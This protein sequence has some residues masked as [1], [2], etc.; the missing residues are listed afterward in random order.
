MKKILLATALSAALSTSVQADTLL[1]LYVGG[2]IWATEASGTFGDNANNQADFNLDDQ[3]QGSFYVAFEHPLPLIPNVKVARTSLDTDGITTLSGSVDFRGET[4]DTTS[5]VATKFD[6]TYTDYTLYYEIFDNDL[7]S[8]D[9]GITG[10]DFDTEITLTQEGK[11]SGTLSATGIVPM[12]YAYTNIGLPFTGFNVFG[13][14]NFLSVGDHSLY[15]FQVGVSYE[16]IDNLAV[17][18]NLTL[19]YR[20][21]QLEVD[22]L[23]NLYSNLD[24]KGVFAGA[25]VHF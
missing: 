5:E 16:L 8:V 24:F 3:S 9:F 4:Y 12:L 7:V 1:G 23:D 2:Q 10:R 22:D 13:E 15:D 14:G 21:V 19:G 20:A 17:D 18:V 6:L 11:N 25:V